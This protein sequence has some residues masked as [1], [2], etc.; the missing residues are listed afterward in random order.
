VVEVVVMVE[1]VEVTEVMVGEAIEGAEEVIEEVIEGEAIEVEV[2]GVEA[3]VTMEEEG[4]MEELE[5]AEAEAGVEDG[6]GAILITTLVIT[7]VTTIIRPTCG[8]IINYLFLVI[9]FITK[10]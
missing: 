9:E 3:E 4:I 5:T 1:V 10:N 7:R 8:I 2:I 6:G